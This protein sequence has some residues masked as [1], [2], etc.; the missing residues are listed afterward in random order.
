MYILN[1]AI[2]AVAVL[3]LGIPGRPLRRMK[4]FSNLEIGARVF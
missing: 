2:T 1:V 4:T 3:G